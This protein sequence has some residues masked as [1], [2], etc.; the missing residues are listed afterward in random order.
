MRGTIFASNTSAHYLYMSLRLKSLM[1]IRVRRLISMHLEWRVM[2]NVS[3]T[4]VVLLSL[5]LCG[6]TQSNELNEPPAIQRNI[7]ETIRTKYKHS[8]PAFGK[9][10]EVIKR[11]LATGKTRIGGLRIAS[12]TPLL[13]SLRNCQSCPH[14]RVFQQYLQSNRPTKIR[15]PIVSS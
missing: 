2:Q 4:A 8:K 11:S 3:I 7:V 5:C 10:S 13:D 9:A 15:L 14:F 12:D 6:S 1:P